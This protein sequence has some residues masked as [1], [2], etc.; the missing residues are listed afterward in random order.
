VGH[1]IGRNFKLSGAPLHL[2]GLFKLGQAT[3]LNLEASAARHVI[4]WSPSI[5]FLMGVVTFEAQLEHAN[6]HA[7]SIIFVIL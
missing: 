1:G 5:S 3:I 6:Q 4:R 7:Q 2:L